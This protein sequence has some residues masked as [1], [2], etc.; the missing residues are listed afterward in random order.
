MVQLVSMALAT[1]VAVAA[2]ANDDAAM[3]VTSSSSGDAGLQTL[4][5]Y[6]VPL[7]EVRFRLRVCPTSSPALPEKLPNDHDA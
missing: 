1:A 4:T 3:S 6:V 7:I 2:M 5:A